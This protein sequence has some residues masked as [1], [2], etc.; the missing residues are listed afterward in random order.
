[1]VYHCI[2][3]TKQA[4]HANFGSYAQAAAWGYP[5]RTPGGTLRGDIRAVGIETVD[6]PGGGPGQSYSLSQ[7][8]RITLVLVLARQCRELGLDPLA[9]HTIEEHAGY[10]DPS[11]TED[12]G[13]AIFVPD[14][15]LDV[16]DLMA[17]RTPWRTVGQFAYGRPAPDT[18]R[19]VTPP[20]PPPPPVPTKYNVSVVYSE[21]ADN[22]TVTLVLPKDAKVEASGF[23][24]K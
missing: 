9:D 10:G 23:G 3:L 19:P 12:L 2:P 24:D 5:V 15:R 22:K 14:V 7:E 8:T 16:A 1:M 17:G 4:F 13:D 20:P 11:R 21:G 18:W 6:I